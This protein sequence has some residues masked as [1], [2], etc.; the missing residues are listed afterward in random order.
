MKAAAYSRSCSE[1]SAVCGDAMRMAPGGA[2]RAPVRPPLF[3][4]PGEEGLAELA[5][6]RLGVRA[7]LGGL[8]RP[9]FGLLA[10]Q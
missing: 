7:H 4:E 2:D 9:A 5:L 10:R 6:D 3:G 1:S 8:L